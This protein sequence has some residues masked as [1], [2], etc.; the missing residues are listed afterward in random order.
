MHIS[1]ELLEYQTVVW[2]GK[3]YVMTLMGFGLTIAPNGY[4]CLLDHPAFADVDKYVDDVF[5]PSVSVDAVAAR[6]LKYGLPTTLAQQVTSA[7]V[8]SLQLQCNAEGD[9]VWH[10]RGVDLALS[11]NLTKRDVPRWCGRLTGNVP[12]CGWLHPHCTFSSGWPTL[13][14][15]HG[16]N[17]PRTRLTQLAVCGVQQ[18]SIAQSGQKLQTLVSELWWISA[19]QLLRIIHVCDQLATSVI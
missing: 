8:L 4:N 5:K 14:A 17:H 13:S 3:P 7:R 16:T 15:I 2:Q 12:V 6:L 9:V 1:P 11:A 19:M 10:W 18:R